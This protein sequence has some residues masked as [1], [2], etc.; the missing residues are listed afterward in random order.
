MQSPVCDP[1]LTPPPDPLDSP[2]P[3]EVRPA[4][5]LHLGSWGRHGAPLTQSTAVGRAAGPLRHPRGHAEP[6]LTPPT[7][8]AGIP[9]AQAGNRVRGHTER[10]R[11]VRPPFTGEGGPTW[12]TSSQA[13][14]AMQALPTSEEQGRG[15]CEV[16]SPTGPTCSPTPVTSEQDEVLR[17]RVLASR[18][19]LCHMD[20]TSSPHCHSLQPHQATRQE[21]GPHS[22]HTKH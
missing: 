12:P 19:A 7:S 20:G 3:L 6:G 8:P 15:R 9:A 21:Q 13:A 11:A 5:R 2:T 10:P 1:C 18:C 4:G 16:Q 14:V 22:C 17:G